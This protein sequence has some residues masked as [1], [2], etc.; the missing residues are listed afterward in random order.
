MKSVQP[1]Q[2][3]YIKIGCIKH[4]LSKRTLINHYLLGSYNCW[5]FENWCFTIS[6]EAHPRDKCSISCFEPNWYKNAL[7]AF[8]RYDI[9][10]N[11]EAPHTSMR[12][13]HIFF[14]TCLQGQ[15]LVFQNNGL[16]ESKGRFG[17]Y[18]FNVDKKIIRW[19]CAWCLRA[20]TAQYISRSLITCNLFFCGS[21]FLSSYG[22]FVRI[23]YSKFLKQTTYFWSAITI[24]SV[25][26]QQLKY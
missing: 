12:V 6:I 18:R 14:S 2:Y 16:K 20:N 19:W 26:P 22:D 15:T 17:N 10:K 23:L 4:E 25:E 24:P 3:I 21:N 5:Y 7:A 8:K 1:V 11:A 13:I 9:W